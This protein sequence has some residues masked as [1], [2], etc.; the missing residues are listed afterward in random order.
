M[1]RVGVIHTLHMPFPF[2]FLGFFL[3]SIENDEYQPRIV[4]APIP[5]LLSYKQII[6]LFF[7][8]LKK[9]LTP[10]SHFCYIVYGRNVSAIVFLAIIWLLYVTLQKKQAFQ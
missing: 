1:Q 7:D 10:G 4:F 5:N 8:I 9:E 3:Y 6:S 2:L